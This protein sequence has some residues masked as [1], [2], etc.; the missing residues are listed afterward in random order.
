MS[1]TL[2]IY[3]AS[4]GSGKTFTLTVEYIY[5]MIHPKADEEEYMRTLA[6][7]FTNKATAEMK[8]RILQH[9]YGIA[10][11]L[12]SSDDYLAELM[13][14]LE[15]EKRGMPVEL[16]RKRCSKALTKILHDYNHF[17]VETIDS[18]FQSILRNLAREL[19]QSSRLQ[20]EL[21]D[22]ELL[23]LAVDRL[24]DSLDTDEKLRKIVVKYVEEELQDGGKWNIKSSLKDFGR[25][26]FHEEFMQRD[27]KNIELISNHHEVM[28][29]R[30]SM[31]EI[32]TGTRT[33][34]T[35]EAMA[36]FKR[37]ESVCLPE[38]YGRYMPAPMSYLLAVADDNQ[39]RKKQVQKNKGFEKAMIEGGSA[40]L[41]A[42]YKKDVSLVAQCDALVQDF[43]AFRQREDSLMR[44]LNTAK[45]ARHYTNQ[46]Q[47]LSRIDQIVRDINDEHDTFPLSRTPTLLSSMVQ[48]DDSAFIYE[49]IGTV[50]K[51][52][53][54]DEFQ[55][56]STL[57]WKNFEILLAENQA[58]GGT[59]LIVGDIKQSIYRWRGGDWS[60]LNEL[61]EEKKTWNPVAKSLDTNFR[62]EKC[63][64]DFNNRFFTKAAEKL[65]TIA[66]D[67]RFLIGGSKGIYYDVEQK[68]PAK[69]EADPQGYCRVQLR[70]KGSTDELSSADETDGMLEDMLTQICELKDKGLPLTQMAILLRKNKHSAIILDYF[71]RNAP[72]DI[73]IASDEAYLLGSSVIATIIVSAMRTLVEEYEDNPVAYRLLMMN[74]FAMQSEQ[75]RACSNLGSDKERC[76]LSKCMDKVQGSSPSMDALMR[77]DM[78]EMKNMLPPFLFN[79]RKRLRQLPLYELVEE[80]YLRFELENTKE[81]D[82]YHYAF[83][84]T[85]QQYL[86][87]NPNDI[88]S[89]L[90]AWDTT[91][92]KQSIP[93]GGHDGI[94]ILTIH[95]S[96]GLEFHTVFMPFCDWKVESDMRETLWCEAEEEGEL[97][98]TLGNMPISKSPTMAQSYYSRRYAEEHLQ[99]RVD[100]LNSLYVAFTRASCNMYVWGSCTDKDVKDDPTVGNLLRTCLPKEANFD[101]NGVWTWE[102]GTPITASKK[103]KK[104]QEEAN[105]MQP[106]YEPHTVN[107]KSF[108]ARLNLN[109]SNEAQEMLDTAGSARA[110][111]VLYHN[112]MQEIRDCKDI[113]PV[114]QHALLQGRLTIEKHRELATLLQQIETD[115]LVAS[116]FSPQ[117]LVFAE[118]NL[119]DPNNPR[120]DKRHQRPDRIVMRGNLITVIDYKFGDEH[121]TYVGQLQRY[122]RLL[123]S[124]YP[125][126]QVQGY[127][128]YVRKGQ[129]TMV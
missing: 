38:H 13:K 54:I 41:L 8:D 90:Q 122:M 85:V 35:D 32:I 66:P 87:D 123:R 74:L 79:E 125:N 101:E 73:V 33:M 63:I 89:F 99:S 31:G 102:D 40:M 78:Q 126:K 84:D 64:V 98:N 30:K 128:W 95:K 109:Q 49:K 47:L 77:C 14:R 76:D 7:T 108:K 92:C 52:I 9:L 43:K 86:H 117:N 48:K 120:R 24:I 112:I 26:I 36:L 50:L 53:M 110:E 1:S 68:L 44:R 100:E 15:D 37:M 21:N 29:F 116:W 69:R 55:D 118:C 127:L 22:Q 28:K 113:A 46:L 104:S 11:G 42:K 23:D 83:L 97:F 56:T 58:Q 62:S 10:K 106:A 39:Q 124:M 111:G 114:L 67:S 3:R 121:D 4:A 51:N 119:L 94:R 2:K 25:C 16:V 18:F 57:Q 105:R 61:P 45:L 20:V 34:L 65:D 103:Q 27:K 70:M 93:S 5:L 6:V 80:L 88:I 19:K 82:A 59:D 81:Q 129:Y 91:L 96:K 17:R 60:L 71:H 72:K 75:R 12:P 115:E 107:M